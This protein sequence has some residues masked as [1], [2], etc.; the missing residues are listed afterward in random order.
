MLSLAWTLAPCLQTCP[1][2]RMASCVPL[3]LVLVP[4]A[5]PA[6]EPSG[7]RL[8]RGGAVS[9]CRSSWVSPCPLTG[10]AFF[11]CH[12]V[13][14][15]ASKANTVLARWKRAGSYL[16]EELFEGNLEKECYEEICVYEEAREVFE[17]DA[18]T[19][20]APH[21]ELSPELRASESTVS[22]GRS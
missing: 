20:C 6:A 14:L 16:L 10:S 4:L 22:Q 21:R 17:N 19:V 12:A 3:L 2:G 13:F 1:R 5:V 7:G 8:L 11:P 9:R 18:I 15:S